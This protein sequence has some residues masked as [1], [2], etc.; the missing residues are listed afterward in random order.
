MRAESAFAV[1]PRFSADRHLA[2]ACEACPDAAAGRLHP[3]LRQS[4]GHGNRSRD[5]CM[6]GVSATSF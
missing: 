2:P 5:C 3:R 4:G 6:P 1:D